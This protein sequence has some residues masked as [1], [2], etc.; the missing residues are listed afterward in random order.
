[1]AL[2]DASFGGAFTGA[3]PFSLADVAVANNSNRALYIFVTLD[4]PSKDVTAVSRNGQAAERIFNGAAAYD[5]RLQIWRI[6][7]PTAGTYPVSVSVSAAGDVYVG[8]V[9]VYNVNQATPNGNAVSSTAPGNPASLTVTASSASDLVLDCHGVSS[10]APATFTP[11]NGQTATFA[12]GARYY[13]SFA[14]SSKAA[15]AGNVTMSQSWTGPASL[16]GEVY[17]ALVVNDAGAGGGGGDTQAPTITAAAV[18][19]STPTVVALTASETLDSTNIPAASAFTV[20]GHTVQSVAVAGAVINL[21][22]TPA[23]VNGEAARTV[24]YTQPGSSGIRD[25]AG[26]LLASFSGLAVTNNV[27]PAG[28]TMAPAFV[29]AQVTNSQP[30]VILVT[31]SETLASSAP[32]NSAFTPSGGRTAINVSING[33]VAAVTVNTPYAY[34]DTINISYTQPGA[35]P[36]LQ[37]VAGNPTAT[38]AAQPVSNSINAPASGSFK[39][40][41]IGNNTESLWPQGTEVLWEWRKGWRV[42][43]AATSITYGTATVGADRTITATGLPQGDGAL[44]VGKR[45]ATDFKQDDFGGEP[46]T[47]V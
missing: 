36:R 37:D 24:D 41:P 26:N 12:S 5:V 20:S 16:N 6:M 23:F 3:G 14:G 10:G 35:N 29:S 30:N 2:R 39:S 43:Q 33:T 32:P 21:T 31:M 18:A 42:G 4:S 13:R 7:A 25:A 47:V 1:M 46:G 19:N 34:G 8:A 38:F 15:S 11:G 27:Q 40:S 17:A 9:S 45:H 44:F 22:V 28:D